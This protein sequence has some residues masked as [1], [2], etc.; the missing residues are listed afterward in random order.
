M[1]KENSAARSPADFRILDRTPERKN[2]A[3]FNSRSKIDTLHGPPTEIMEIKVTKPGGI[4]GFDH[5]YMLR[6]GSCFELKSP[7][8]ADSPKP[9]LFTRDQRTSSLGPF[10]KNDFS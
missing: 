9:K 2:F 7:Q 1:R 6:N 4:G 3:L 10:Q 8:I 5:S